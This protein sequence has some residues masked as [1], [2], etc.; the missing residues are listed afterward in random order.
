MGIMHYVKRQDAPYRTIQP[1][2]SVTKR[3]L[4]QVLT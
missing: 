1:V 2:L 3:H 4:F